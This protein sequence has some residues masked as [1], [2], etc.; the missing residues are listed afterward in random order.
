[1]CNCELQRESSEVDQTTDPAV[2]VGSRSSNFT[3]QM[4]TRAKLDA[5][6]E[7]SF[8][9]G[10]VHCFRMLGALVRFCCE[11]KSENENEDE[12]E[13]VATETTLAQ[14]KIERNCP[15]GD[16]SPALRPS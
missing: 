13:N 14:Q 6:S 16:S 2:S 4:K 7:R 10:E 12:N 5:G 1:M 9:Q 3:A 15:N 11:D 8:L